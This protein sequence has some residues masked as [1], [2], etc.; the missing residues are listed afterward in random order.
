M[1]GQPATA[2]TR[3]TACCRRPATSHSARRAHKQGRV[4][5]ANAAGGD[6]RFAGSLGTQVVKVFELALARTGLTEAEASGAGF[7]PVT[8]AAEAPD[9][10][11]YYPGA[12]VLRIRW[13]ADR[14]TR[15]VLG[16]QIAG[17]VSGQVAKR[18]DIAA[19]AI[20]ARMTIDEISDLD[21]S[22]APPLG[23]PWDA[24]QV[25]AQAWRPD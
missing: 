14:G 7:D 20:H 2:S 8:V 5:G 12:Q 10:K 21:L 17:H 3:T 13:T 6:Q 18:I 16:C 4:A 9:H 24:L 19:A 11:P 15:R 23:S 1:S 22:Y 25:G